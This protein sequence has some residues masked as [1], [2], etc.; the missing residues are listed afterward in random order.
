[1]YEEEQPRI[2]WLHKCATCK[3]R[4]SRD[5]ST[6]SK[7]SFDFGGGEYTW[8]C[9][10]ACAKKDYQTK[11]NRGQAIDRITREIKNG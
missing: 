1:M 9:S 5:M 10:K 11:R 7:Y 3:K 4:L 8:F 6:I 2:P